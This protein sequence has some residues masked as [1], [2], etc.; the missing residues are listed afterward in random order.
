MP[1]NTNILLV[2][3]DDKL[4]AEFDSALAS[5]GDVHAVVHHAGEHRQ[6]TEAIGNRP[7][8]LALIELSTDLRPLKAFA[9]EVNRSSPDTTVAAVFRPET[10]EADVSESA[11]LIEA[12]RIGVKDFL[13]RPLSS[14][15]LGQLLSRT[16]HD[17]PRSKK[18][19]KVVAFISNKG[20]V[21]KSTTAVNAACGLAL[22]HPDQVLLIDAS[23]QLGVCA[24]MLDLQPTTSLTDV[25]TERERLDETL[26]R[27]MALVHDS[28][29]HVLA[30]PADAIEAAQV[31]DDLL[32]RVIT[33]ARRTYDFV[34][35][36]TF[37]VFD[38]NL[39]AILDAADLAYV[40]VESVVPTLMGTARMLKVLDSLDFPAE[41]RHILLN[42]YAKVLGCLSPV[43][44]ADQLGQPIDHVFPY[45]K[46]FLIAANA[47]QPLALNPPRFSK[48]RKEIRQLIANIEAINPAPVT[49]SNGFA[50][51]GRSTSQDAVASETDAAQGEF[52]EE[53]HD[54]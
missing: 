45:D 49:P 24:S 39:I 51:N 46:R 7:P 6:A 15:E 8:H 48:I 47:G 37:P 22:R 54:G 40:V 17:R 21:G 20:G 32:S 13:R 12:I 28:G 50:G 34:V 38:R 1:E 42:R 53:S 2:G 18:R 5:L 30:A 26:I 36:D 29:L 3:F 44:V 52:T 23:L 43:E 31:D 41:K 16:R 4:R 25:A 11:L 35:L 10:F 9:E 19:G 14:N 33:L 27:Q